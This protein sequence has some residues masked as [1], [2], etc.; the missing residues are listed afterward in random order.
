MLCRNDSWPII[1]AWIEESQQVKQ[2]VF[3]TLEPFF[4]VLWA[5]AVAGCRIDGGPDSA[6]ARPPGITAQQWLE[7]PI[8]LARNRW[9]QKLLAFN[10]LLVKFSAGRYPVVQPLLRGPSELLNELVGWEEAVLG[11]ATG[12][13]V[14]AAVLQKCTELF[15]ALLKGVQERQPT[16]RGGWCLGHY[17]LWSPRPSCRFQE[18]GATLYSP[19]IYRQYLKSCDER[20]AAAWPYYNVVHQHFSHRFLLDEV[21][22]LPS[23]KSVEFDMDWEERIQELIPSLQQVQRAGKCLIVDGYMSWAT[24]T[25]LAKH[26]DYA[27][28]LFHVRKHTLAEATEFSRQFYDYFSGG[29]ET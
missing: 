14:Y 13:K 21:L 4:G 15:I 7:T 26:L 9:F 3:F 25:T 22:H 23:L 11:L 17:R 8:D 12:E 29:G 2:D 28:L 5:N 18:D 19:A 24:L 20:I 10:D 1:S 16:F 6:W 27:G